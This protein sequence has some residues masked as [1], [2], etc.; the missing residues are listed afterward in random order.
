MLGPVKKQNKKILAAQTKFWEAENFTALVEYTRGI[1]DDLP[2]EPVDDG[3]ATVSE[4]YSLFSYGLW[5]TTQDRVQVEPFAKRA[6]QFN[7][8]NTEALWLLREM[9]SE[10]SPDTKLFDI[11]VEGLF[12]KPLQ[13]ESRRLPF[14]TSYVVAA[15]AQDDALRLVVD[16][17]T[18]DIGRDLEIIDASVLE[19]RPDLPK[20]VY[21]TMG[22]TFFDSQP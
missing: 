14:V 20:G 3:D 18:D 15:D 1:S 11:E 10:C 17:E 16:I 8:V 2:A 4:I 9:R 5:Y 7:R 21:K 12:G 6:F 22:L 13:G 19:Q